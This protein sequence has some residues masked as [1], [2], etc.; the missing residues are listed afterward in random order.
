MDK[1]HKN[2]FQDSELK[3]YLDKLIFLVES[4]AIYFWP[5]TYKITVKLH[6][7]IDLINEI[8]N[9]L[10]KGMNIPGILIAY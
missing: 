6:H 5:A 8:W 9:N 7:N 3:V 10:S 1:F 2:E 4:A